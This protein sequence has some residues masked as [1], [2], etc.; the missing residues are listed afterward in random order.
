MRPSAICT[1][2][3]QK[4]LAGAVVLVKACVVGFHTLVGCGSDQPSHT[5]K[6]P[7]CINTDW[8]ATSGHVCK[9]DHCPWPGDDDTIGVTGLDGT[10]S[11]PVPTAFVA[12]TVK[13]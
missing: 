5:R 8:I 1:S 4:M 10:D 11:R 6:F 9:V 2:P 12:L 7:L 3:A 13:V